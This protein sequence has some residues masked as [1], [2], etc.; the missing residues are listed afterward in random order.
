MSFLGPGNHNAI[1]AHLADLMRERVDIMNIH[2]RGCCIG[3]QIQAK[4][5]HL[6]D[7]DHDI[8]LNNTCLTHLT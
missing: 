5:K 1:C 6:V 2:N 8:Q 7:C 4:V 3:K